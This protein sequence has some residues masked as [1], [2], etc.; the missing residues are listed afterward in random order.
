M[1]ERGWKKN[2]KR[3]EF[4]LSFLQSLSISYDFQR[5]WYDSIFYFIGFDW[6]FFY[7]NEIFQNSYVFHANQRGPNRLRASLIL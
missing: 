4:L 1:K 2:F 3:L 5:I 6:N 7:R